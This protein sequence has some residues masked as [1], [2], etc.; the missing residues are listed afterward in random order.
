MSA[1]QGKFRRQEGGRLLGILDLQADG[2]QSA[3]DLRAFSYF[4]EDVLIWSDKLDRL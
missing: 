2:D 4:V 1:L 3:D